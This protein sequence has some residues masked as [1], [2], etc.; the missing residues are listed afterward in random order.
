MKLVLLRGFCYIS[1][2]R[3]EILGAIL[4]R[5]LMTDI[6]EVLLVYIS[7]FTAAVLLETLHI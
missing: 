6:N 1:G 2:P 7:G 4:N 3:S 5:L